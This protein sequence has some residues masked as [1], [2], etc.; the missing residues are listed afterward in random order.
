MAF[1]LPPLPYANDALEP[2]IDARTME[3]HHDKHHNTYVTNLNTALKDSPE[4]QNMSIE[5][6]VANLDKVPESARTAVRNNGG[7]HANHSLF[8]DVL[9]PNGGEPTGALAAS[10]QL[11]LRFARRPEGA[12]GRRRC[13]ALRQRLGLA[14]RR[15]GW[16]PHHHQHPEPGHP[17][18]GRQDPDL[19]DRCLGARLLPEVPEPAPGLPRRRSSMSSTGTPSPSAT[20]QPRAKPRTTAQRIRRPGR[21]ILCRP[22]LFRWEE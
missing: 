11:R 21:H 14:R 7:G 9:G 2:H 8:W 18:D 4:L 19:R 13:R 20:P 6:L 22:G 12:D 3:I 5:E 17:A 10:D 1:E 15:E 16:H